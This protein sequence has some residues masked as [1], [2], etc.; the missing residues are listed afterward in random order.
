M[1]RASKLLTRES[2]GGAAWPAVVAYSG[3]LGTVAVWLVVLVLGFSVLNRSFGLRTAV[4]PPVA[5]NP[6]ERRVRHA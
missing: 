3:L 5:L 2:H 4:G 1:A 6:E